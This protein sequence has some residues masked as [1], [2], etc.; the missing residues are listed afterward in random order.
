MSLSYVTP[1]L[2]ILG[3]RESDIK[4]FYGKGSGFIITDL[5]IYITLY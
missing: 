2:N 3:Y 4:T 5:P 1:I